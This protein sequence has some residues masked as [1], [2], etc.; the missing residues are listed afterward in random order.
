MGLRRTNLVSGKNMGSKYGVIA[1]I[2]WFF[3]NEESGIILEDDCLPAAD[4]FEFSTDLLKYYQN[5]HRVMHI[6]GTN[7]QF[8]HQRGSASY[9]FSRIASIWGWAG[10]RRVWQ[11]CDPK[12]SSFPQFEQEDQM[13]NLF[14]DRRV[15]DWMTNMSRTIYAEKVST[16]D[17]PYAYSIACNNGLCI[18]PNVNLV[19][20]IGFGND[21]TRTKDSSSVHSDIPFGEMQKITHPFLFVADTEAD[22]Y[23]LSLSVNNVKKANSRTFSTKV[24][25]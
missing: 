5:D 24:R 2:D 3:E 17:Y 12:M 25:I 9:Y 11:N 6:G 10:W 1:A 20:N 16:W 23:Q 13:I 4:F 8:G 18:T 19:S 7:L 14:Q 15:A 21:A 22:I